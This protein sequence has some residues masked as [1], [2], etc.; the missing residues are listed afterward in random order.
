MAPGIEAVPALDITVSPQPFYPGVLIKL[1]GL[2][3]A[4]S[5]SVSLKVY[6][7]RGVLVADLSQAYDRQAR[8]AHFH[9]GSLASGIYVLRCIAGSRVFTQRM[10]LLK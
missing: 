6:T 5:A 9:A 3:L 1:R 8:T 4:G 10:T 7:A 2:A